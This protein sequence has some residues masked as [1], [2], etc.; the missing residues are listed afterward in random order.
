ME[1]VLAA[2]TPA[3]FYSTGQNLSEPL[4][5]NYILMGDDNDYV[6]YQ[7]DS[8]IELNAKGDAYVL[9]R[10]YNVIPKMEPD[11]SVLMQVLNDLRRFYPTK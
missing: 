3:R 7:P 9:D 5:R 2:K 4:K 6:V 8:I 1:Q 10:Q 11:V